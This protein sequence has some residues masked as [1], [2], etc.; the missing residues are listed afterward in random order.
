MEVFRTNLLLLEEQQKAVQMLQHSS[1][2]SLSTSTSTTTSTTAN[3]GSGAVAKPELL[4]PPPHHP[5]HHHLK[6]PDFALQQH[7]PI[8][9][10]PIH[11][12]SQPEQ[13]QTHQGG[14]SNPQQLYRDH[15]D[16]SIETVLYL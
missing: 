11:F 9:S 2:S 16:K 13:F 15:I 7:T 4:L 14:G 1:S 12:F 10:Q 5:H 6:F 8:P 3:S